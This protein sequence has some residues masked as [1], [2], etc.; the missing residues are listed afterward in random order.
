MSN[1]TLHWEFRAALRHFRPDGTLAVYMAYVLHANIRARAWP[2]TNLLIVETGWARASVVAAKKWL[3]D[4][5]ALER[6]EYAK[7][8]GADEISLH[9]RLDIMQITG[10]IRLEGVLIPLLYFNQRTNEPVN[11][12]VAESMVTESMV[13]EPKVVTI[14]KDLPIKEVRGR[15]PSPLRKKGYPEKDTRSIDERYAGWDNIE[16]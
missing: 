2:S 8:V 5:G 11:S 16:S 1:T 15:H 3:V 13:T 14:P 12:M 9:Q 7:R 6:V 4:C 10:V